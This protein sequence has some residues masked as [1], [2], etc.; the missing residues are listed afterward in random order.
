MTT[1]TPDQ[2]NP[3]LTRAAGQTWL[4][5]EEIYLRP[6]VPADAE[7][8]SSW[9][10]SP[11]PMAPERA[12]EWIAD[13]LAKNSNP[14]Q[15]AIYLVVRRSNERPVGSVTVDNRHFPHHDV[16]AQLDPLLGDEGFR[17][18]TEALVLVF[19]MLVDE[20]QRPKVS[21]A[22]PADETLVIEALEGI[23]ARTTTRFREKLS[24]PSG[25]RRDELV[26]EYL[27]RDWVARLGDPADVVFPRTGTGQPRPVTAP[28]LPDGDP[29]TNAVRIGPRV[30]LRPPQK[31]DA[32]AVAHWSMR[33]IDTSWDNGRFPVG[34]EGVAK[35]FD[36]TQKKTPPDWIEFSVCLRE[37]DEYLGMVGVLDVNYTHRFGESA[38]MILNSKYRE[39]G[40]GTEAKHLMFDYLFNDLDVHAIQS[41]VM[42]DNPRSAAALRKQGYREAGREHWIEF[43]DGRFVSFVAFDLLATDWRAMPRQDA[44]ID[45]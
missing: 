7:F 9:K 28:V 1:S 14:Y 33:E 15:K 40:Y 35:W 23:G 36:D 10:R 13:D 45:S 6:I 17:L 42:F 27:N 43:R 44:D 12:R 26:V 3:E 4:V 25:G 21:I 20:Q 19:R 31:S 41:W 2:T 8:V 32:E 30:Y 18:K 37:T 29:P 22:L 11:F 24:C 38:S 5:G 16:S 34:R 39:A